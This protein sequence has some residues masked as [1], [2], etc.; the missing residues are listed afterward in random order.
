MTK[1]FLLTFG[2][3]CEAEVKKVLKIKAEKH[4]LKFVSRN[5]KLIPIVDRI[6]AFGLNDEHKVGIFQNK[7][8]IDFDPYFKSLVIIKMNEGS[9]GSK[10]R[11]ITSGQFIEYIKNK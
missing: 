6:H 10:K 1:E 11:L 5:S 9:D 8:L 2:S 3:E 4:V 7:F